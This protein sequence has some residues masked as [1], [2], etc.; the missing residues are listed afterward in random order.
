MDIEARLK[1]YL[2][3][4]LAG[5]VDHTVSVDEPLLDSG[6]I[7]ST[8]IFELIAFI[9]ETFQVQ[10]PD[11]EVVPENFQTIEALAAFVGSKLQ[12]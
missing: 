4:E 8:G 3:E 12:I 10:I 1:S 7:D 11:E 6:L 2:D 5:R 9:E